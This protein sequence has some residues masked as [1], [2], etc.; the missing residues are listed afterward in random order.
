MDLRKFKIFVEDKGVW[1]GWDYVVLPDDRRVPVPPGKYMRV[2]E[3]AMT[4]AFEDLTEEIGEEPDYDFDEPACAVL[5]I[6]GIVE[7]TVR[8]GC[9][10]GAGYRNQLWYGRFPV[11]TF[12]PEVYTIEVEFRYID[13]MEAAIVGG[14]VGGVGCYAITRKVPES[15]AAVAIGGALGYL[16]GG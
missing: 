14:I 3:R 4:F 10:Y 5:S 13:A 1:K 16:V 7:K 2:D 11:A 12:E 15:A 8:L 6:E 9:R